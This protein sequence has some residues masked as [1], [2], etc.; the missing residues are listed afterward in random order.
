MFTDILG[1]KRAAAKI[2]TKLINFEQKQCRMDFAQQILTKF[3]H[4]PDLL[5][6]ALTGGESWLY[7]YDI[8]I[9]AQ[10]YQWKCPEETKTENSTSSSVKC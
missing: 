8:E 6:K 5:K 10:S 1:T 2:V 7:S 3:K 4:D 9:K